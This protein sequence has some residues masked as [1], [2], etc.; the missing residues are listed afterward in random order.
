VGW[1][2]PGR[3]QFLIPSL[4]LTVLFLRFFWSFRESS[5]LTALSPD[6]R[7]VV[8]QSG[9]VGF[10]P[11]DESSEDL[12]LWDIDRQSV[13]ILGSH[14]DRVSSCVFT[15]DGTRIVSASADRTLKIWD[16]ASGTNLATLTGHTLDVTHC[17]VSPDGRLIGSASLDTTLRTW[18]ASSGAAL[19]TFTGHTGPLLS[20]AFSPDGQVI[21]STDGTLKLWE[22]ATGNQLGDFGAGWNFTRVV[23]ARDGDRLILTTEGGQTVLIETKN[24]IPSPLCVTAWR[25]APAGANWIDC[26]VCGNRQSIAECDLGTVVICARCERRFQLNHFTI[27][28]L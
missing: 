3:R 10:E 16:V 4:L 15:P 13:C 11:G 12:R 19:R 2:V 9:A 8:S 21:A 26:P 24:L 28:T 23:W 25:S 7:F 17:V 18:D 22:V 27:Q 20:C 5:R 1:S 6:G 14:S